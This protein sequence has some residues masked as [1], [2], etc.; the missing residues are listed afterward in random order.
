MAMK[1]KMRRR[2]G[3]G[4]II[5]IDKNIA[6]I[7]GMIMAVAGVIVL[8]TYFSSQQQTRTLDLAA[9]NNQLLINDAKTTRQLQQAEQLQRQMEHKDIMNNITAIVDQRVKQTEQSQRL[10][11]NA[12][13][14]I[15]TDIVKKLDH[16]INNTTSN[17]NLT[18]LNSAYLK[19]TNDILHKLLASGTITYTPNAPPPS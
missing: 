3:G 9:H 1:E 15:T 17:L 16:H 13:A 19:D 5:M 14:R 6:L 12:V 11:D 4:V 18:K 2:K 7:L 8:N 10:V